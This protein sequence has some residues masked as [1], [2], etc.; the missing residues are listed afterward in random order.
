VVLSAAACGPCDEPEAS[1][2]WAFATAAAEHHDVWVV[3]RPR[4]RAE[5]EAEL[6]ADPL[7]AGHLHVE[8]L[9]LPA[10]V[11]RL[12]R[13][14]WDLYWYYALWQLALARRVR[15]LH[16]THH[17]DVG[18]HVTFANDWLPCGL[19][20][21]KQLPIVWGPVGGAST[22]S[23][24]GFRRWLGLKGFLGEVARVVGTGVPRRLWGDPVARRAAVVVAQND[25][26]ATRFRA[27]RRVVV[28][29]NAALEPVPAPADRRLVGSGPRTALFV[30]RLIA[31]KGARLALATLA[32]PLAVGWRLQV[33]GDGYERERLV[34]LA[35]ELGISDRVEFLGH[36][37]RSEVLAAYGTAD[38]MLFP[39]LHDQ[40]GWVVA[41]A[42]SAGCPVVC[43]PLGGPP[44]LA[45]PNAH[46]ASLE[47]DVVANL[48][49]Q[50]VAAGESR[51][52]PHTRWSRE[53]LVG[54]VDDWYADAIESASAT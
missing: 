38:A 22:F 13:H 26:V 29:P 5:M 54:L 25:D 2:G 41:E 33:F 10:A 6:S 43:L 32:H 18:H 35:A 46:V 45:G 4:F 50:L 53:R 34:A 20:R 28:E 37:P 17:F 16:R 21:V 30:G 27:A 44:I 48:A 19:N 3:T 47:G 11:Q 7:L 24:W 39:S 40:A 8:Y 15:R 31:W 52:E 49:E 23:F 9:D 42:S 1:A 14:S 36:R 12:R 51:G